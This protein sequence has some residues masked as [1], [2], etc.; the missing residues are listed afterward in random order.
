MRQVYDK[1]HTNPVFQGGWVVPVGLGTLGLLFKRPFG[2]YRAIQRPYWGC[3]GGTL[4]NGTAQD[5]LIHGGRRE[6]RQP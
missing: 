2:E 5:P 6:P 4:L 3:I 1:V